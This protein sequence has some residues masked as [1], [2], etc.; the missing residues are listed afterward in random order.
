M[1]FPGLLT[2]AE[3]GQKINALLV[4]PEIPGGTYWGFEHALPFI[5][6]PFAKKKATMPSLALLTIPGFFPANYQFKYVD[7]NIEELS[8][9]D[10]EW[11][12]MVLTSSMIV[13]A[14]SLREVVDR[15]KA[16]GKMM[17]HGGPLP[18]ENFDILRNDDGIFVLNEAELTLK[19][20]IEDISKG[21]L[22]N[23]YA[24]PSSPMQLE[25]LIQKFGCGED[26]DIKLETERV[27]LESTPP[28][29][30][31]LVKMDRYNSMPIQ[32]S[33]GCW[34]GCTYCGVIQLNGPR[35]RYMPVNTTIQ[36]LTTLYN[37]GWRG[38]VFVSDDNTIG[39]YGYAKETFEAIAKWQK[40]RSYPIQF[41]TE[42]SVNFADD[43][44]MLKSYVDAGGT[45]GFIG[46]ETPNVKSLAECN[47]WINL[48]DLMN[49]EGLER[50]EML[51]LSP[52]REKELSEK[53]L[54]QII[55]KTHKIQQAGI[56]VYYGLMAGFDNDPKETFD[57]HIRMIQEA[58]VPVSMFGLL[59]VLKGSKFYEQLKK[60]GRLTGE[61]EGSNTHN[62]TTNY[63]RDGFAELNDTE[64][65]AGYKRVLETIYD[66]SLENYLARCQVLIDNIGEYKKFAGE[67]GVVEVSAFARI[68]AK[69][70]GRPY[71]SQLR[72][73]LWHNATH[74]PSM[75][76][77]ACRLIVFGYHFREITERS[78]M[79]DELHGYVESAHESFMDRVK[80]RFEEVKREIAG[81]QARVGEAR[82]DVMEHI[83]QYRKTVEDFVTE[84]RETLMIRV[85]SYFN[86]Q[87][88]KFRKKMKKSYDDAINSLVEK[89]SSIELPKIDIDYRPG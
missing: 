73:F 51:E 78:V 35:T 50:E 9:K 44:N 28:V 42:I 68:M 65:A 10:I 66:S 53:L 38:N 81:Y 24:R 7:M 2:K 45:F 17:V 49:E 5:T 71:S 84:E 56:E 83:A 61:L 59:G 70:I 33:R 37:L 4:Y 34:V 75:F 27:S 30:Y 25:D 3:L 32:F 22:K 86:N 6:K 76:S 12:D 19:L 43:E 15:T 80:G 11:S 48:R 88:R 89:V 13:Q 36:N 64:L 69:C 62:F 20:F 46:I 16:H 21:C 54:Q 40:A 67:I 74:N 87:P 77:E 63:K 79:E 82:D 39:H 31:D 85:N 60:Q 58:G 14:D 52:E 8:D 47:K 1:K 26:T 57:R 29:R 41:G 55:K 18:T 23:V 72:K